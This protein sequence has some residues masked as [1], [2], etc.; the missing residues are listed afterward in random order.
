[1]QSEK[2]NLIRSPFNYTGGKHRL[3]P[4][5]LPFFPEDIDV[6]ADIFCGGASVGINASAK[7]I[8]LNDISHAVTGMLS[9]MQS[10]SY[11]CL[12][13]ELMRLIKR[14]CLS[15][16]F[17]YGYSYYGCDSSH[18]LSSVNRDGFNALRDRLNSL[19]TDND[20]YFVYLFLLVVYSFNNQIRFNSCGKFNLP[21]GKRDFNRNMRNKLKNF[22]SFL[23]SKECVISNASFSSYEAGSN[24]FVY[25]DPPY[26][27]TCASYNE[28]NGWNEELERK[29]LNYLDSL[30][31]RNIKFA[32]SNVL[33]AEG[34]ENVILKEWV[35][36]RGYI[37][38]HLQYSYANSNYHKKQP[39]GKYDEVLIT[40]YDKI[41][42]L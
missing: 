2:V 30:S 31:D 5:I 19:N 27:I 25:A 38:N 23:H 24:S 37:V 26:L 39:G 42:I 40:N 14:Y 4:Q 9:M 22:M 20:M 21:V 41:S 35:K 6:F 11:D 13:A 34:K 8:V 10:F 28:N 17:K 7:R 18:G 36:S 16:T 15:D 29:L 12:E 33:T 3:L 32:L 1:M